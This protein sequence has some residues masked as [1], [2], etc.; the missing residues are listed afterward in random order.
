MKTA[1][2]IIILFITAVQGHNLRRGSVESRSGSR[3]TA[4]IGGVEKGARHLNFA[5]RATPG[6]S[7]NLNHGTIVEEGRTFGNSNHQLFGSEDTQ[8]LT[9]G[10]G[11]SSIG[12]PGETLARGVQPLSS[13]GG[14]VVES[15]T[16]KA[17]I[18][19]AETYI[20]ATGKASPSGPDLVTTTAEIPVET[21]EVKPAMEPTR[22]GSPEETPEENNSPHN[23]L[24]VESVPNRRPQA[25]G[26]SLSNLQRNTPYGGYI[27]GAVPVTGGAL[28]GIQMEETSGPIPHSGRIGD[29][30]PTNGETRPITAEIEPDEEAEPV[31]GVTANGMPEEI[32]E[33][34]FDET[35]EET[36]KGSEGDDGR[37]KS[38]ISG[39]DS[40]NYPRTS[41][42]P[43][44]RPGADLNR[45]FP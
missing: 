4:Q 3:W 40:P 38:Q 2:S 31:T 37:Q 44:R 35:Q 39:A 34:T 17:E 11:I 12:T 6:E 8:P 28:R 1:N 14:N 22:N 16:T 25:F 42:L 32:L 5:Q 45:G 36:P 26:S 23:Y 19:T 43:N 27:A 21:V 41:S 29:A 10:G 15:P 9:W 20:E 30:E 7:F 33:E 13:T 18:G 24:Q